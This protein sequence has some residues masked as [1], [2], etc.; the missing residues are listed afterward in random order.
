MSIIKIMIHRADKY[1]LALFILV[2]L[3]Y[4]LW[5]QERQAKKKIKRTK[6]N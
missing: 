6:L 1:L 3:F 2:S 5:K 4:C